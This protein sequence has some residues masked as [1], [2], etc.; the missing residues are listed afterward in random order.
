VSSATLGL[1][2]G[3][4]AGLAA[5]AVNWAFFS[6]IEQNAVKGLDRDAAEA[7]RSMYGTLRIGVLVADVVIFGLVGWIAGGTL[8]G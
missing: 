2:L 3:V 6:K 7:K 4:L 8:F 5:G 1:L